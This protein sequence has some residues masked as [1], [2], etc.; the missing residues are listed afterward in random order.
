MP[1]LLRHHH[2]AKCI[3]P[4]QGPVAPSELIPLAEE[5]GLIL[6]LTEWV[7]ETACVEAEAQEATGSSASTPVAVLEIGIW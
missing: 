2:R 5:S 4:E 6:P 7:L 3:P 1:R